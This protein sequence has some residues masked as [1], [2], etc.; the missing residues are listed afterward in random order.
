VFVFGGRSGGG[1]HFL[2]GGHGHPDTPADP[3][4]RQCP[5]SDPAAD[6]L[7]IH[8]HRF[9]RL[10]DGQDARQARGDMGALLRF[11]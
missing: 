4:A 10:L 9:R 1:E 7:V 2:H 11:E 8:L 6:G 3:D 5:V